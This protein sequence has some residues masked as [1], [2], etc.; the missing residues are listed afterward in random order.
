MGGALHQGIIGAEATLF[1]EQADDQS[2][3]GRFFPRVLA[4]AERLW[5]DPS[6]DFRAAEPRLLL[7]RERIVENGIRAEALQPKWCRQ[8]EGQC[9]NW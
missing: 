5:S 7:Q 8:N 9:P 6:T 1:A 3:D 4:L 2:I